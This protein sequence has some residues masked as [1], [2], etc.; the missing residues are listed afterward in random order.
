[1]KRIIFLSLILIFIISSSVQA[2]SWAYPFVVWK[3]NVY[4]VKQEEITEESK[5]GKIIGEV[6]TKPDDM[7]GNYYGDTSNYYPKGTK[8]YEIK[9][10][11]TSTA[12]AIKEDNQWVKAVYVHKA[13]FHI[14]NILSNTFFISS[15]VIIA[16]IVIGVII[17]QTKQSKKSRI[18]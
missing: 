5:I 3:G 13:P 6:K 8:Y 2:L 10:T 4:E 12:I 9:G 18:T 7:T 15:V 11:S 16:L 17:F 1:M 14:M